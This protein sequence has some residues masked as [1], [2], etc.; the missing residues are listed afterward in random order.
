MGCSTLCIHCSISLSDYF[1]SSELSGFT[2]SK[3]YIFGAV[4]QPKIKQVI[5][6][7]SVSVHEVMGFVPSAT[8][9]KGKEERGQK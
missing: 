7:M 5:K 3:E 9:K 6:H 8:K 2:E 1:L 4:G